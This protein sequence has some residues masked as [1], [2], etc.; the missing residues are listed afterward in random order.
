[1]EN[2]KIKQSNFIYLIIISIVFANLFIGWAF[3]NLRIFSLPINEIMI[4][5]LL[6]Q[7]K[8]FIIIDYLKKVVKIFPYIFW[9]IFG[10]IYLVVGFT[11]EGVWALRDGSHVIDSLYLIIGFFIISNKKNYNN[12]FIHLKYFTW[13]GL[14]YL[15]LF[16]IKGAIQ[17]FLP[18]IAGT[19][20]YGVSNSVFNYTSISTTWVWLGFFVVLNYQ[21][22]NLNIFI[23]KIIPI[24]LICFAVIIFQQ[25]TIYISIMGILIFYGTYSS[26]GKKIFLYPF[27]F[28]FIIFLISL[29]EIQIKGRIGDASLAFFSE[30]IMSL[31]G[32]SSERTLASSGTVDQR[33]VWVQELYEKSFSS[34]SRFFLGAGYGKPLIDFGLG[35]GVVAREPHNSYLSI[36]G[37]MGLIG[38]VVWTYMHL[39]FFRTWNKYYQYSKLNNMNDDKNKLLG[40]MAFILMILISGISNSMFAQTWIAS[41]YYLFWGIIFR[42]CFN[43]EIRKKEIKTTY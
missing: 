39:H 43:I 25:R 7:I 41:I 8:P 29:F 27:I 36:Y 37:K 31:F 33:M 15:L 20:G 19:A 9:L 21:K 14:I 10:F 34:A 13:I 6:T 32:F 4:F 38:T 11:A 16:P 3:Q 35:S 17:G 26:I 22:E 12:L 1:M 28:L 18:T 30:H 5:L 40:F 24:L 23:H 42:I 2:Y